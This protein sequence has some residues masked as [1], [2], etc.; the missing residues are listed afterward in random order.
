MLVHLPK[1]GPVVLTSDTVY[2]PENLNKDLL[3]SIALAYDPA[4]ILRG[5]QWIKHLRDAEGADVLM[6]HDAE[7]YKQH[8]HS[9]EFYE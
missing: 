8:K 4:G 2:M 7:G 9:P 3:P 5:Y 1:T 6:A